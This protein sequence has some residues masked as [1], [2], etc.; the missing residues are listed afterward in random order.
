MTWALIAIA[1]GIIL[2][3]VSWFFFDSTLRHASFNCGV[4]GYSLFFAGTALVAVHYCFGVVTTLQIVLWTAI[5][6]MVALFTAFSLYIHW[7]K[8]KPQEEDAP[9]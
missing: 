9:R 5:G 4:V 6:V 7:S 3:I 2:M 1:L 8:P